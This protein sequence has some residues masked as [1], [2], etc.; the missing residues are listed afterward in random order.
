MKNNDQQTMSMSS[1][2]HR[3]EG[4]RSERLS[5]SA[6][7]RIKLNVA[8]KQDSGVGCNEEI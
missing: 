1:I 8:G 2:A 5:S 3:V 7:F 6:Q 4:L